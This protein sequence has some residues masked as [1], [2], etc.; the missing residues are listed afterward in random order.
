M[1]GL[2]GGGP[3]FVG[4]LIGYRATS[5]ILFVLFLTLAAGALLYVISEMFS[6]SRR[7]NSAP[8]LGWGVLA[9]FLAGYATDLVLTYAGT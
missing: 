4:T 6:V 9:G 7:L 1:T 3:T 5:D 2:I 8:L